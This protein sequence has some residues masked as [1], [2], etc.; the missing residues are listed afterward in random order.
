MKILIAE[1]DAASLNILTAQL[2]KLDHEVFATRDGREALE[3][4]PRFLPEMVITDWMMPNIDGLELCRQIRHMNLPSYVYVMILT[5]MD[6]KVG[7]L[8]GMNAGADD[9]VNKP[10]DSVELTVRLR[11]AHRILSLQTT[12]AQLEGLLPI[13]PKCRRIKTEQGAWQ[14]VE[15]YISKTTEARFSHGICPTCFETKM[16]PQLEKMKREGAAGA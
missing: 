2:G 8:D 13:C 4:I 15:S 5:S 14:A 9:F 11:A 7:F 12:V 10:C 3:A 1:D 16:R 6:R